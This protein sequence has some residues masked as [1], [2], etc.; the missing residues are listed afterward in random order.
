MKKSG[1]NIGE[2]LWDGQQ[3]FVHDG[4]VDADGYGVLIGFEDGKLVK[5]SGRGNM[6]FGN[7]DYKMRRATEEEKL[8]FLSKVWNTR[9]IYDRNEV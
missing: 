9:T 4:F 6:C 8:E 3:C 7:D 1:F 2:I 5:S